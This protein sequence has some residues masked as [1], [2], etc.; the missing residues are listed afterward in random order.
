MHVL[1]VVPIFVSAGSAVFPAILGAI[2]SL[3]AVALKPRE[4]L[5][6]C[7]SRPLAAVATVC[8]IGIVTAAV[9]FWINSPNKALAR[10]VKTPARVDWAR[11]AEDIL[12]QAP[13]HA[14]VTTRSDV[15]G[16][17]AGYFA[18]Y[19]HASYDGGQI[20]LQLKPY[21]HF[22]PEQ[23]MFL[24]KPAIAGGRIIA[25]GCQSDLG[26]Y[27]G[28]LACVDVQTG[29]P[30][31]QITDNGGDPLLPFFSSPALTADGK[32]VIIGQ[33]LHNDRD[34]SLL[35][36]NTDSGK[37]QWAVKTP[38]HIESS[39]AISGDLAVVGA[40]AIEGP[41]GKA[42]GNPGYVLA[43]RI[44]EGK[45]LWRFAVNDPESS[46][47]IDRDGTV[48][49]GS[50]F[51]GNAMVA[52]RSSS[53][54]ALQSQHLSR[55]LWRT[56]V[57]EPVTGEVTLAGDLVIVGA[58]NGDFVHSDRNASG[59]VMALDRKTGAVQWQTPMG[60]SVLGAIA[61]RDGKVICPCRSGEVLALEIA[62]GSILWRAR[63]SGTAPVLAGCAF[64]GKS[65]Y[66]VSG[67]GYLA[68]IDAEN[69]QI[70]E[71]TYLNDQAKPG[72]GLTGCTPQVAG[73]RVIVGSE[74]GGLACLVGAG[75]SGRA[76]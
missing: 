12:A 68:V 27:T 51:N 29:K 54:E 42:I 71:K 22:R 30:L 21:W 31:W 58:G 26:G 34:C 23:T 64:T 19:T 70:L 35:C 8:G 65:V 28:L 37:L 5:R 62:D 67:D 1:A 36:F 50:G 63:V 25:A 13:A 10:G 59:L 74:T 11:V 75:E 57:S 4:L 3:V 72:T 9:V 39:P 33:G 2:G 24:S 45:E 20:P 7:R 15:Q 48:F 40:G 46:P 52:L 43:V 69:G 44:S 41:D 55:L 56:A 32:Y 66:A 60:D 18:D 49:I 38:L 17:T 6:I 16:S 76:R 14:V 47:A 73:G 61:V 53:D